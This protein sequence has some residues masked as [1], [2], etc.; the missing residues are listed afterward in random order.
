MENIEKDVE[1]LRTEISENL[2]QR[3]MTEDDLLKGI[4]EAAD[5]KNDK[6][7]WKEIEIIRANKKLFTFRIRPLTSDEI[8]HCAKVG[9]KFKMNKGRKEVVDVDI[10]KVKKESIY[11]ATI[12]EDKVK[13][14]DNP[15]VQESLN[16]LRGPDVIELTLRPGEIE[17]IIDQINELSGYKVDYDI[18]EIEEIKN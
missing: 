16:V 2:S 3:K 15:K 11:T 8:E 14:W 13:I 17:A 1:L 10:E 4:L 6:D 5:Y 9:Q 18:S 7:L 12:E